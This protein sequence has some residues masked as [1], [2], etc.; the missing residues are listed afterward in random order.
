MSPTKCRIDVPPGWHTPPQAMKKSDCEGRENKFFPRFLPHTHTKVIILYLPLPSICIASFPSPYPHHG[1]S[2][3]RPTLVHLH[4]AREDLTARNV[5]WCA[6]RNCSVGIGSSSSTTTTSS[7]SSITAVIEKR[8]CQVKADGRG[9]NLPRH[10]YI[11]C[12]ESLWV[13]IYCSIFS[14]SIRCWMPNTVIHWC[15]PDQHCRCLC[16]CVL[17]EK[18]S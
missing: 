8:F 5:Y 4:V 11:L 2:V 12:I 6:A 18:S 10:A 3:V 17:S 1:H 13:S 7:S 15:G 14:L 9:E 16:H